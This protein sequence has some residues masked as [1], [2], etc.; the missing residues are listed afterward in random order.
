[1]KITT[2]P[3]SL[4]VDHVDL[5]PSEGEALDIA[6]GKGRNALYLASRGLNVTGIDSDPESVAACRAEAERQSLQVQA[7]A[8]DALSWEMGRE[9]YDVI[10]NFYFLERALSPRIIAALKPGGVLFFETYTLAQLSLPYG[11]R[12][13]LWVLHPAELPLMFRDLKTLFYRDT[14]LEE[15]GRRKAIASLIARKQ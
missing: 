13:P 2:A 3:A 8:A 5:L 15:E 1:M 7:V 9:R 12:N 10:L 4:L 6:M 11:P 14:V